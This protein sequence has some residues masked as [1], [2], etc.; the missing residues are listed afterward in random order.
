M[1]LNIFSVKLNQIFTTDQ[2]IDDK[3]D[4][5]NKILVIPPT[6]YVMMR[7]YHIFNENGIY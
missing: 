2:F 6:I 7:F 1:I 3:Q 4:T 5:T